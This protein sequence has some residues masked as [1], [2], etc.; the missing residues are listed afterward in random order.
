MQKLRSDKNVRI[1][2][3][4]V[5]QIECNPEMKQ[6]L[7]SK[8]SAASSRKDVAK[9]DNNSCYGKTL[10]SDERYDTSVIVNNQQQF[11]SKTIGK[12][13]SDFNVLAPCNNDHNGIVELKIKKTNVTIKSPKYLG[14]AILAYSK[15]LMLD[16]VYNCLAVTFTSN[17]YDIF[18]QTQIVFI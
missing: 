1:L 7:A 4:I 15:M 17:E 5:S 10:Q 12:V 6:V 16:F 18:T 2:F 8:L 11:M 3:Q 9:L 13:I 14:A